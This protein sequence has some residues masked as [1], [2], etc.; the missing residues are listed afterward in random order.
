[1]GATPASGRAGDDAAL[2]L[3]MPIMPKPLDGREG[4][5]IDDGGGKVEPDGGCTT[6]TVMGAG[7]S[8][9]TSSM[10][11]KSCFGGT[12]SGPGMTAGSGEAGAG[13]RWPDFVAA[14]SRRLRV[15]MCSAFCDRLRLSRVVAELGPFVGEIGVAMDG[16]RAVWLD[17]RWNGGGGCRGGGCKGGTALADEYPGGGCNGGGWR[18]G[19]AF[20][21]GLSL[22]GCDAA[23]GFAGTR[24]GD[25]VASELAKESFK[26]LELEGLCFGVSSAL[27]DVLLLN[28]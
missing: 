11:L 13:H 15:W 28:R 4:F 16:K 1:M 6:A 21:G 20:V 8:S 9:S 27:S 2:R 22:G 10:M 17:G 12:P 26:S 25:G 24:G 7:G 18:A 19:T 5:N 23:A 3:A 14:S